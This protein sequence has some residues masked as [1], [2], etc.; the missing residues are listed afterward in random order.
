[1]EYMG[2]SLNTIAPRYV[3]FI[4]PCDFVFDFLHNFDLFDDQF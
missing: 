4:V 3:G 1:M 2:H